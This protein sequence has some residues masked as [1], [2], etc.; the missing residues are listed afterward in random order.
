MKLNIYTAVWGEKYVNQFEHGLLWS[1]N[2]PENAKSLANAPWYIM[3]KKEDMHNV[4]DICNRKCKF[5]KDIRIVEFP[6]H[7]FTPK[8]ECGHGLLHGIISM[9]IES[10]QQNAKLLIAPPDTV[11]GEGSIRN[12]LKIGERDY[13]CV[14][15]PHVRVTPSIVNH[16]H[17]TIQNDELVELAFRKE[18]LHESWVGAEIGEK[19]HNT[20][21]SGV[22]WRRIS[23]QMYSVQHLMPTVY[24]A[25]FH[26][27]DLD[28]FYGVQSFGS[29]DHTWPGECLI[30]QQRQRYVG[31]SDLAFLVELTDAEK[32]IPPPV[33]FNPPEYRPEPDAFYRDGFH[34]DMNKQVISSFRGKEIFYEN[35]QET[36]TP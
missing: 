27:K 32:N 25:H 30:R 22:A 23:P 31:S 19:I 28:F 29:W 3:T 11:Y 17:G 6:T 36:K 13:T 7:M 20:Y 5:T 14:A 16:L 21:M 33:T 8:T 15:V 4:A 18:Y 34:N 35:N 12:I 1:L 2:Q 24:L 10:L 9:I 26:Q